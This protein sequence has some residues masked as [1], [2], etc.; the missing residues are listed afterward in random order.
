MSSHTDLVNKRKRLNIYKNSEQ[1]ADNITDYRCGR[2]LADGQQVP[3]PR[4]STPNVVAVSTPNV[5]AVSTAS[6]AGAGD[7]TELLNGRYCKHLFKNEK[8]STENLIKWRLG[9][10]YTEESHAAPAASQAPLTQSAMPTQAPS[11]AAH[12]AQGSQ[13]GNVDGIY[14]PDL[15]FNCQDTEYGNDNTKEMYEEGVRVC[16]SA[17]A[18]SGAAHGRNVSTSDTR[19]IF[20]RGKEFWTNYNGL[21]KK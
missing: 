17:Q 20:S 8:K 11:G 2:V 10:L 12:A 16:E 14:N 21:I 1:D 6:G 3:P 18:P 19:S 7:N 13:P 15:K 9:Q 4:V 5:V